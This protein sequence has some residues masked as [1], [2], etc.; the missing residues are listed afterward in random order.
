MSAHSSALAHIGNVRSASMKLD[1]RLSWEH[2]RTE[3][4]GAGERKRWPLAATLAND[5]A[6][7]TVPYAGHSRAANG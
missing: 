3:R 5:N 1:R 7:P 6:Y 2:V 4:M